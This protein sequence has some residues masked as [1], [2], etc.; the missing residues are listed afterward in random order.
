VIVVAIRE[1]LT[2][3]PQPQGGNPPNFNRVRITQLGHEWAQG[4]GPVPED[5]QG[6]LTA[7]KVQ[8]PQ[9]DSIIDQYVQEAVAAYARQMFFASAV[10]IGAA[11]EKTIYLLI[12]ALA[13][14]L[15]DHK[16]KA[17]IIKTIKERRLPTMFKQLQDNLSRAKKF[18]PW[19][20]HEGA[21]AHLLSLQ[22]AIRVQRNDAVHPQAG[23]VTP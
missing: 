15:K 5:Q 17:A 16:E 2:V 3:V 1:K 18:M 13:S 23:K 20:V 10:M 19:E 8:V 6:F 7:L 12:D 11:S 21:E 9:L 14:S 22:E 4:N